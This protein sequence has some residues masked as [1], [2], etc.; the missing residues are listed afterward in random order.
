MWIIILQ[1]RRL[2]QTSFSRRSSWQGERTQ[3]EECRCMQRTFHRRNVQLPKSA[4]RG[5]CATD[6]RR[7]SSA[8][9]VQGRATKAS[10]K[11]A[12]ETR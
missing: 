1:M 5:R 12:N 4:P 8:Q 2:G 9:F 10:S 7:I 11:S 6:E 3:V